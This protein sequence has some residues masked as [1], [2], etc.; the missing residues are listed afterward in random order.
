MQ[1]KGL[2]ER[3]IRRFQV[4]PFV[5]RRFFRSSTEVEHINGEVHIEAAPFLGPIQVGPAVHL[6]RHPIDCDCG[7][8]R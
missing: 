1:E 4:S 3:L 6:C 7:C 2:Y 5:K 8:G